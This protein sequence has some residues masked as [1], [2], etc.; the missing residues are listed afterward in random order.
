[1]HKLGNTLDLFYTE[2]IKAI[3]VLH[4]FIGNYASD[5]KIVGIELQLKWKTRKKT[6]KKK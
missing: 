2:S 5:H 6:K 1:M 3:E 4:K